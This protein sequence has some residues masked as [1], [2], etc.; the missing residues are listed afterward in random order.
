M[1]V[2]APVCVCAC[3]CACMEAS[4]IFLPFTFHQ[5]LGVRWFVLLTSQDLPKESQQL[6]SKPS[7]QLCC[8]YT[9]ER[10][11]GEGGGGRVGGRG[12][13]GGGSGISIL[14]T[15]QI[16]VKLLTYSEV[17]S[18]V[19]GASLGGADVCVGSAVV[20][21]H[22]QLP[23]SLICEEEVSCQLQR[24]CDER[25]VVDWMVGLNINQLHKYI[26]TILTELPIGQQYKSLKQYCT[27]VPHYNSTFSTK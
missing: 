1:C 10:T 21:E 20:I 24:G 16:Q 11:W 3:V 22:L 2:R 8:K 23:S 15:T 6:K 26:H 14:I 12:G 25:D 17:C 27:Y 7:E 18:T 9:Q 13:G 19:G 4:H 5:A